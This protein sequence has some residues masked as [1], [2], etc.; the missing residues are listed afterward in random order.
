[1]LPQA[2]TEPHPQENSGEAYY[3]L[4]EDWNLIESS[5]VKQYGIR[6]RQDDDM[7][8][9]E[10]CSLLTGIMYDTPLGR[11][12]EIRSEKDPKVIKEF[13]KEEKRIYNEWRY[14]RKE[15]VYQGKTE[16]LTYENFWKDFQ[17]E[18]KKMF[19]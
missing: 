15:K 10:F 18:A 3:D 9:D 17:K 16:K 6:L 12:V 11:V 13:T 2:I 14:R 4:I 19:S 1:M 8:W 7:S 5:F